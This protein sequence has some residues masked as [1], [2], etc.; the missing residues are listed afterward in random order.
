VTTGF[1]TDRYELTMLDAALKDGTA[2]RQCVFE[3]FARR[4]RG[5]RRYGVVAGTGRLMEA[6]K[7]FKF[8]LSMPGWL[9]DQGIVSKET[10]N[11]LMDYKFTG[12]IEGYLEGELYFPG[13]PILTVRGTFAECV[14]LETLALSILNYDS[15]IATAA[16][17]MVNAADGKPL[18]EMGSRRAHEDAAVAA[19]R[20]AYIAGFASTSN[21]EAGYKYGVPTTGTSAHAFILLHETEEDAFR[22]QV[23]TM[24]EKTTLL[25]DTYDVERAV[26]T[27]VKVGGNQ[28]GAVRLDSGDYKTLIP[29]V[30]AQLDFHGAFETKI[31]VTGDLDEDSIASLSS[32]HV[33]GFGVGT[34][35]ISGG[36][37]PTA[38]F[39][40]KLVEVDG[41]KVE[42][43]SA[44]GSKATRGGRKYAYRYKAGFGDRGSEHVFLHDA[45]EHMEYNGRPLQVRFVVDGVIQP[46]PTLEESRAHH[47]AALRELPAIARSLS[48]SDPALP[49]TYMS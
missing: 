4:L 49:T 39:V 47:I 26:E 3:L 1:N 12:N 5:G 34:K 20:A 11:W 29:D 33:D 15:A 38:E 27:A 14:I 16:S 6:L 10:A 43:R 17:R 13:S 22:S 36:G 46:L 9:V 30:R 7:D 32:L 35:L 25:V 21:L 42:K 28:L 18:I 8:N 40:Y 44:D 31:I 2:Y 48:P 37:Y 23:E 19:A 24:G 45:W 41:R